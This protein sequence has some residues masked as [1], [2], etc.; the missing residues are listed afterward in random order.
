MHGFDHENDPVSH[1]FP[2]SD[3]SLETAVALVV[4]FAAF[5]VVA[6]VVPVDIPV[7]IAVVT[8][9]VDAAD[10]A[11]DNTVTVAVAVVVAVVA[12]VAVA[13]GSVANCMDMNISSGA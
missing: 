7:V 11:V 8:A 3:E 13:V 2:I 6:V 4:V 5:D 9:V 12:V 1:V 10:V